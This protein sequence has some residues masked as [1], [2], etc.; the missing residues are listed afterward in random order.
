[1]PG[2]YKVG[3]AFVQ[4][5]ASFDK[6]Q[7]DVAAAFARVSDLTVSVKAKL[8][9]RQFSEEVE[10]GIR[11]AE[12]GD[13]VSVDVTG[14]TTKFTGDVAKAIDEVGHTS[15]TVKIG[16]DDRPLATR[17]AEIT[18][19]DVEKKIKIEADLAGYEAELAAL[20]A[21]PEEVRVRLE[22]DFARLNEDI[23]AKKAE[24]HDIKVKIDA[25]IA[26]YIAKMA[27]ANAAA[28]DLRRKT[29]KP[30]LDIDAGSFVSG[31]FTARSQA[32]AVFAAVVIGAPLAG[33]ALISGLGLG[34]ITV[35]LLAEKSNAQIKASFKGLEQEI[36]ATAQA[37]A[38]QLVP[39]FVGAI[40]QIDAS[41]Q[42]LG[43]DIAKAMSF[44]GPDVVALTRGID[45]LATNAM[46][47]LTTAM[48]NSLPV[49][50]GLA[51]FLGEVGSAVSAAF[52]SM[53][54]HSVAYGE[55]L[56][57]LGQLFNTVLTTV[58]TLVNQLA[59]VWAAADTPIVGAIGKI[60]SAATGLTQG[61]LGP[62]TSALKIVAGTLQAVFTVLGPIAPALGALG[63]TA[64]VAFGAFKLAPLVT[65][66]V[67]ALAGG[68]L[69]LGVSMETA[70]VQGAAQILTLQGVAAESAVATEAVTSTAL[71]VTAAGSSA[72]GAS[73]GF[74]SLAASLAGPIGIA[75][76]AGIVL[77][78][79]GD[80]AAKWAG[81]S[82]ATTQLTGNTDDL[83]AAL[84]REHGAFTVAAMDALKASPDFK[85]AASQ[86]SEFG[87]SADD[88]ATALAQGGPA[89]DEIR[90][91]IQDVIAAHP[92]TVG[93]AFT[94]IGSAKDIFTGVASGLDKVGQSAQS[95][96]GIL[97]Q[98][99]AE[100]GKSTSTA[101][102]SAASQ[103]RVASAMA[104]SSQ[105][106]QAAA[107]VA[108]TLGLGIGDVTRGFQAIIPAAGGANAT[109]A[110]V[111]EQFGKLNLGVHQAATAMADHFVQA[112]E[113]VVQATTAVA[114][115]ERSH[116]KSIEGVAD[117]QHS[118]AQ[119]AQ[120][121]AS[122]RQGEANATHAQAQAQQTLRDSYTGITVAENNLTKA[123]G[124]AR[125]AQVA[126]NRAREQAVQDLK[127]LHLQ[128]EDQVLSEEQ[129][130]ARLF[131]AETA[132]AA[133]GVTGNNAKAIAAQRVTTANESQVKA[134]FDIVSAQNG[135]NDS[136]NSGVKLRKQVAD[137]DAA[138][139][140]GSS[141][142]VSAQKA[143]QSAQDQVASAT[144]ALAKAHDAVKTAEWGVQQ[145]DLA[146]DAA[147]RGVADAS[148]ALQ[149]AHQ[150]VRDAQ[151]QERISSENLSSAK[152]KLR[153]A[154]DK[155]SRSIDA[156][157]KA[158]Q[159]NITQIY[160]L[161]DAIQ[162][163]GKP[164][165]EQWQTA[166]DNVAASLGISKQKA[167]DYLVQLGLIPPGIQTLVDVH[168]S[169]AQRKL[170]QFKADNAIVGMT[171][172]LNVTT[173]GTPVINWTDTSGALHTLGRLTVAKAMG[174]IVKFF[175]GGGFSQPM[176]AGVAA[177]VP[178][179]TLRV[180][181]D[182][183]RDDEA[184]IPI[185]R[186]SRSVAVLAETATR[187]GFQIE[188]LA[189]GGIFDA[190][191]YAEGGVALPPGYSTSAPVGT[192][193]RSAQWDS[194]PGPSSSRSIS[195][196][197]NARTE[198]SPEHI[199]HTIDRHLARATRL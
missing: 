172:M 87:I 49:F 100:V 153:D 83:T 164:R 90:K 51:T 131:D 98:L 16:G 23:E 106:Q 110:A 44:A 178:P 17:L 63:G 152:D 52:N 29:I 5:V 117:A 151:D 60:F 7:E 12:K 25:D 195:I 159:E 2:G 143:L 130:Q 73:I 10:K 148:Y 86:L 15:A 58:V 69:S 136:L 9:E 170:D 20:K 183:S 28:D 21:Q 122:A 196:I 108:H 197:V 18:A 144:T 160:G 102:A 120:G 175:A 59:E 111:A 113:A 85:A 1:M 92:E 97:N 40:N 46:P 114:S 125:A 134:A 26:E 81:W 188:P 27:A 179:N 123:Q 89:L 66:G 184:Y 39:A 124:D 142:V 32:Q 71:A 189:L 138:G 168:V 121:V 126:L 45:N 74:A 14:D 55:A 149:K 176:S 147:H 50:Q 24:L 141:V 57:T 139:V 116:Q 13:W 154:Q 162:K 119:A 95:G 161:W 3:D 70:S 187:M 53:S 64:L 145:A 128:L 181:G 186:D 103:D 62:L 77:V 38:D 158:G 4:V 137:A 156:N 112:D 31:M 129:A 193:V 76:A 47:G 36:K 165:M 118:E 99:A 133:L 78:M 72:A 163:T 132:G 42:K 68:V 166:V 11:E 41:V 94:R 84:E 8:D 171:A 67:N 157:T 174:G 173:Q 177:V 37:G 182:R 194:L 80:M 198:A 146:L 127:D 155:A 140:A 75:V 150:A 192:P 65:A 79:L 54:Q 199:A 191:P 169:A 101:N 180:I 167:Y 30:K 22:A 56:I 35:A 88:L 34:F 6:F 91:R 61:A 109:V 19:A 107:G 93:D 185:N 115:A 96:L 48:Q 104:N 190:T 43:P 105:F 135:V 33:S 82:T